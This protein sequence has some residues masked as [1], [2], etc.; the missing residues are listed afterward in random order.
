MKCI[1]KLLGKYF[2]LIQTIRGYALADN[3]NLPRTCEPSQDAFLYGIINDYTG[4]ER[5]IIQTRL[6]II[7]SQIYRGLVT[8]RLDHHKIR[9]TPTRVLVYNIFIFSLR[10]L[11]LFVT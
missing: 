4:S 5:E 8:I 9:Y 7:I 11:C 10:F 2:Y 1:C 3:H 6:K